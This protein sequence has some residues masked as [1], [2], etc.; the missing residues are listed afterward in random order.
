MSK[1][2]I[3][4]IDIGSNAPKM[5]IAEEGPDG[6]PRIIETLRATLSLGVDT[7]NNQIISESSMSRL[8]NQLLLF[9]QKLTEYQVKEYR[10][11]A[12]SAVREALN[13]DF[14]L[15][16]IS[17]L[18]GME[19]EVLSNSEERYFH[20]LV[21]SETFSE[22]REVVKQSAIILDLGAGSIQISSYADGRRL[23]SQNVKL[24]Y[25]RVSELFSQLQAR[26]GD[27][28][29]VMNEY[30]GS[31][32][33]ALE[34]YDSYNNSPPALIAVGNDLGYLRVFAGLLEAD[35]TYLSATA[36]EALYERLLRVTP[37]DL[38]LH[39]GMP[40]DVAE[41]LLP[42][43]MIIYR[44]LKQY[45]VAGLYIPAMQLG[46]G[47]LMDMAKTAFHFRPA[48]DHDADLL[49]SARMMAL[50]FG[51][52]LTHL[53][54]KERDAAVIA[55][56][57]GKK[58][59]LNER[60][61]IL[62]KT[63]VWLS[64]IGKFIH[65]V[66]Y[67]VYS[68]EIIQHSEFVGL[69]DRETEIISS[70]IR[71]LPG[72]DVPVDPGLNYHSYNHRLTVLQITGILRLVD[73]LEIAREAKIKHLKAVLKKRTLTLQIESEA[74]WTL[75]GWAVSERARLMNELFGLQVRLL[76]TDSSKE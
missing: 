2:R 11:V 40:A 7:Y 17:Q 59:F 71:F 34:L 72:N 56:A 41:I 53:E 22:Y 76:V 25:L 37:L 38:T 16:R 42:A 30:I 26:S 24:G 47:L 14:V 36:L 58:Y 15:A 49:S 69:S 20:N 10:V 48:H 6:R 29:Q 66:N 62:L 64:E 33:D 35:D 3:A 8:C 13:R 9:K 57:L 1:K 23:M 18:T 68:A 50:R 63:A 52:K 5:M 70:S 55:K 73:A 44:F 75:E 28:S 19:C 51:G 31:Q 27:F 60:F 65:T 32:L 46:Q 12:T 74:D 39:H 61:I 67:A 4:A 43:A 54:A 21:L 45:K